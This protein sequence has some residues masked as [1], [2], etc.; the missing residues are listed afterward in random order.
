MLSKE[1]LME[2]NIQMV[3]DGEPIEIDFTGYNKCH[4]Y[5]MAQ[6]SK[7][8]E[9]AL[10]DLQLYAICDTLS[11][12]K[13]TQLKSYKEDIEETLKYYEDTTDV[14]AYLDNKM[15]FRYAHRDYIYNKQEKE[16]KESIEI[17][18]LNT[19]FIQFKWKGYISEVSNLVNELKR[20][21]S[22]KW[23]KINADWT[24]KVN[25]ESL[26]KVINE[27]EKNGYNTEALKECL[28]NLDIYY[29]EWKA[30]EEEFKRNNIIT[31]IPTEN[32]DIITIQ[33][34]KTVEK[35]TLYADL[36]KICSELG[37]NVNAYYDQIYSVEC[38]IENILALKNVFDNNDD[39][40]FD[41]ENLNEYIEL[42]K[43]YMEEKIPLKD[44]NELDLKHTPYDYQIQDS[45]LLLEQK[46]MIIGSEMG[47][48]KT[49]IAC[50]VGESIKRPKLV[51]CPASLRLNW[52]REIQNVNK[53]SDISII[54]SKD[55]EV[56][57]SNDW[58]IIAYNSLEKHKEILQKQKFDV[59]MIDEAHL[60]QA[61]N[62]YGEPKSKRA[63]NVMELCA[64]ST[65]VYPITGTPKTSRNKNVFNILRLVKNKEVREAKFAFFNF[66]Q[67]Y[68]DPQH[69]GYGW[70]FEGNSNDKELFEVINSSMI[71][72]LK[73][74]VLPDLKKQRISIPL[75]CNLKSYN[76]IIDEF[77]SAYSEENKNAT[78]TYLGYMMKAR[79]LLSELKINDTIEFCDS[80]VEEEKKVVIVS[81]FRDTIA[82]IKEHYKDDCVVIQG[83]MTDE[84]KQYSID[85]FQNGNA[86]VCAM[87][88]IAGGVGITLTSSYNLVF[89][90]FDWTPANIIQ[91]EDRICRTGQKELCNIFYMY[92]DGA[93]IDEQF[94]KMLDEKLD[95]INNAIDNGTNEKVNLENDIFN[96]LLE[97]HK[98]EKKP[99]KTKKS[100]PK[101]TN[102]ERT[103]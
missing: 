103:R 27:F 37:L 58:N 14:Q 62:N 26:E 41:F 52:K 73:K 10:T 87:N 66:G 17:I 11:Y 69:N 38:P 64:K 15:L 45:K 54:Y 18:K 85:T 31:A 93:D 49:M 25:W 21:N 55:K 74:D 59:V 44:L 99:K 12:Y 90:D 79:K 33:F 94:V 89:N 68:C 16:A 75:E 2:L 4:F 86:K 30:Q 76:K 92:A 28:E 57:I 82:K 5:R 56:K 98:I 60:C 101:K 48:G 19:K 35:G 34:D 80:L 51:I 83:G 100:I 43:K 65:Y 7:L 72:H 96:A 1:Q 36:M 91:A 20:N 81:C 77:M 95:T 53:D 61:I 84:E 63:K 70:N 13:N 46:R 39:A 47:A 24:L 88:I 32:V 50:L 67:K 3:D 71:R 8:P 97:K 102:T 40:I 29:E 78:D 42:N 22:A 9:E 6:L 23:E